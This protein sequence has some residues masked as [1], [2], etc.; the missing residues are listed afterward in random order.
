[1]GQNLE[2]VSIEVADKAIKTFDLPS[3]KKCEIFE[4]KGYHARRATEM[5]GKDSSLYMPLLMAQ[6]VHIDGKAIVYEDLDEIP[7]KDYQSLMAE[8]A[9][10]NF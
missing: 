3:G 6:L 8:F 5:M 7:L 9:E 4:G 2:S 10:Q 1:M